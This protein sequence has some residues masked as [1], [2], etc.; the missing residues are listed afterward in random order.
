M[1]TFNAKKRPVSGVH[2]TSLG[3][4]RYDAMPR[5]EKDQLVEWRMGDPRLKQHGK[6]HDA[7]TERHRTPELRDRQEPGA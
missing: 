5:D 4:A 3:I 1:T 2:I 7:R 6:D